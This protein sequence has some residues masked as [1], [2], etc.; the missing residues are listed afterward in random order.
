V[1][2][3]ADE[4]AALPRPD[5]C[6]IVSVPA[7]AKDASGY[8]GARHLDLSLGELVDLR[9]AVLTAALGNYAPDVVVVDRH[10]RGFAGELEG[11]LDALP[12]STRVVLGLRDVLDEPR[13]ASAEWATCEGTAALD[14]W[15]DEVWVYG[16][17]RV[18]D[19]VDALHL[20]PSWRDR[21]RYTGYL[22]PRPATS[23]KRPPASGEVVCLVGGGGDGRLLAEA[24]AKATW[25]AGEGL[26]VLGPQMSKRDR[27]DVRSSAAGRGDLEVVDFVADLAPRVAGAGA[28]VTMGGYNTVCEMLAHRIP[29]LVVPRVRPRL[30]QLVRAERLAEL[31]LLDVLHPD[32]ATPDSISGWL[33]GVGGRRVPPGEAQIDI[34]GIVAVPRLLHLLAARRGT[35]HPEVVDVAV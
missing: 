8:Y 18:F 26:L 3:G 17:P 10:P 6:D 34:D 27:Y 25:P 11:A 4:A 1:L 15:Y 16:D 14:R 12:S 33:H 9:G 13:V 31:G 21:V 7:L 32:D 29:T 2:T 30:E 5:G 19:C 35:F 24:F 28:A 20:P 22:A 23:H